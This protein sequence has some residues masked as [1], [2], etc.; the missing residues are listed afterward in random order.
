MTV[1]NKKYIY[2]HKRG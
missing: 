2:N 1:K